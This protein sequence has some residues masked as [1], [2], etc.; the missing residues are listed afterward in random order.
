MVHNGTY[1]PNKPAPARAGGW[2]VLSRERGMGELMET[3]REKREKGS[4]DR[5]TEEPFWNRQA[6][7][8]TI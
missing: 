1:P 6:E 7:Y 5:R 2:Q 4:N 3:E 8:T